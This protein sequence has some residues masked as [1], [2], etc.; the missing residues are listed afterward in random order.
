MPT[1]TLPETFADAFTVPSTGGLDIAVYRV[2][3]RPDGGKEPAPALIWAHANGFNAGC[4]L[5]L[6]RRLSDHFHVF[7]YDARGHGASSRPLD[8]LERDYAMVR[9]AEDLSAIA[10]R[11]RW[12][13]GDGVPLHFASH[14]LGGLA[15]VL[16]EAELDEAPFDSLTLFEPPIY[17]PVGH[18]ERAAALVHS[19]IFVRWAA[20]RQG[21]FPDREALRDEVQNIITYRR[22]SDEMMAAYLDAAVEPDEDSESGLVL[23]CPGRI[24]A[25]IYDNCPD[26]GIFELTAK[27]ATRTRLFATDQEV[28]PE[29][30]SWAP[31]TMK[32]IAKNMVRAEARTMPG[33][34]HLMVQE[35]PDACAAAVI[36]HA[37]G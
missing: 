7:A 36:E 3:N 28:L 37:L 22:F 6:L 5:P 33:C 21:R 32:S 31:E 10:A 23:R 34:L 26:S 29:L 1:P 8:D 30:H 15:A 12:M 18:V 17:P 27:V 13:I 24:E 19:P 14:S 11:V 4:Y 9:F 16:L 35:N 25:A 2:L 20:G